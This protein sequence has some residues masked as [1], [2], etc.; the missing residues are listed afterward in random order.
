MEDKNVAEKAPAAPAKS[1]SNIGMMILLVIACIAL[2]ILSVII[3]QNLEIK[4]ITEISGAK[5][6]QTAV[7]FS[8]L[9]TKIKIYSLLKPIIYS[10]LCGV[11]F[12]S[13]L[14]FWFTRKKYKK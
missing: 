10:F 9:F 4:T 13:P 11:I 2:L 1:G 8:V 3:I 5:M 14:V 12:A 7:I 6:G